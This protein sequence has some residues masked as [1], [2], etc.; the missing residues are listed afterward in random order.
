[1]TLLL[2]P[3]ISAWGG[4]LL[5]FLWQGMLIGIVAAF[6]L[7]LSKQARPQIRYGVACTALLL[8]VALPLF[9][10]WHA[11]PQDSAD[12]K[13]LATTNEFII[14]GLENDTGLSTNT[15]A[16]SFSSQ[17]PWVVIAWALGCAFFSLRMAGGLWWISSARRNSSANHHFSLQF[18]LEKMSAR[19]G[20]VRHIELRLCNEIES[21]VTA[22]WWKP[23]IF[24]PTALIS[25]MPPDYIEALLAH[26][27]AHIKRYDYLVNLIQSAIEAVLFFHPVVWWL[28]KQIRIER[29]NIADD[30]AAEVLG[31]PRKLAVALAAL[32]EYQLAGP[33]LAPAAQGGNLM[34]RIQRLIKPTEHILGWKISA[35]LV[36]LV[37][38]CMT[39]YAYDKSSSP[40]VAGTPANAVAP[41]AVVE[42]EDV[43]E[44]TEVMEVEPLEMVERAEAPDADDVV[45]AAAEA[46]DADEDH[47]ITINNMDR[48]ET[49]ALVVAGKDGMM[50]SGSISDIKTIEKTRK[51]LDGDFLWFRRDGKTYVVQDPA[52]LSKVKKAWQGSDKLSAQMEALSAKMEVHS[53]VMEGISTKMEAVSN[54]GEDRSEVMEKTGRDMQVIS[55]QQEVIGRQMRAISERMSVAKS[56][57]Q[58][59]MI[60]SDMR[61]QQGKMRVLDKQ[62][63]KLAA[64]MEQH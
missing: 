14:S 10:A 59:E 39:A 26:E 23:V 16:N 44:A 31:E 15:L 5:D 53:K 62:M 8:C 52:V 28:S 37:F 36:C 43:A 13:F 33:L 55:K 50:L 40:G 17:I 51:N 21:P 4:A 54:G 47:D 60:E 56:N 42:A 32:D 58:R 45:E 12:A 57:Q 49:Y 7:R 34:S 29:E 6:L 30:L 38:A 46:A 24:L 2:T 27:L 41:V 18:S 22:G 20:F 25:K 64:V 9:N 11:L 63:E 19:F 3:V 61:V 48:H 1:M 35:A